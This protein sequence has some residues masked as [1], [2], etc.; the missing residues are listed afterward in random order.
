MS[1]KMKSTKGEREGGEIHTNFH[2]LEKKNG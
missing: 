1:S 2:N